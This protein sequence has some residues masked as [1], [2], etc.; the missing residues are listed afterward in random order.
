MT[1][2]AYNAG[3]TEGKRKEVMI[4]VRVAPC[5]AVNRMTFRAVLRIIRLNMVG[6]RRTEIILEM[7][8][9]TLYSLW[10]KPQKRCRQ[11]A[12]GTLCGIMRSYERKTAFLMNLGNILDNP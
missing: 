11:M 7:T 3:M 9:V 12:L 10:F 5:K 4:N 6:L 2:A 8:V 1:F